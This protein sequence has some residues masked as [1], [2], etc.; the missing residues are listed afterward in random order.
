MEGGNHENDV[1]QQDERQE[2]RPKTKLGIPDLEHS[3]AAVLRSLG[4]RTPGADISMPLMSSSLGTVLNHD[5]PS[6][7]RWF[8]ATG[9]TSRNAALLLGRSMCG[10]PPRGVWLSR[11]PTPVC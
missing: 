1:Y 4:S 3:K 2:D 8:Y 6:T 10:W 9:F 7:K 11:R 5:W